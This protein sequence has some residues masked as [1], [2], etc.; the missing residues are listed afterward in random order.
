MVK[1]AYAMSVAIPRGKKG[2]VRA[3]RGDRV[4][5]WIINVVMFVVLLVVMYPLVYIVS[6]SFSSPDAVASGRVFLLPVEPTLEGYVAVFR[7]KNIMTGYGNTIFY[8]VT[9][10]VIT[11]L[12]T[13]IAA[14]PLSRDDLRFRSPLMLLFTFTMIFSGGMIPNYMLMRDLRLLNTRLAMIIPGAISVY[15][16]IITRTF[17]KQ[18]IPREL[19][20]AAQIDRCTDF[21]F[22]MRIVLPLSK[23]VIAVIAL[24]YAVAHWNAYFNA[25]LYLNDKALFPLQIILRDI[26]VSNSIDPTLVTDPELM[27]AKRGMADLLKYALIVVSSA[28]VLCLYPFVQ[29]HFVQGVMIGSIKG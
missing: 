6:A 26:L 19:L 16:M 5:Y 2:R 7:E 9:G 21:G 1:G 22:F 12:M 10:T 4:F 11:I 3:G 20:E 29:R 28:P 23:S 27:S 17:F 24:Y 15:N 25:F 13:L 14:Y 8:T 18:T